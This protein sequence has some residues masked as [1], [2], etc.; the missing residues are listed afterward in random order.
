[1]DRLE[2]CMDELRVLARSDD[3][4]RA[5]SVERH[6]DAFSRPRQAVCGKP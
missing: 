4:D 5:V 2:T 6:I 1:M 3:P